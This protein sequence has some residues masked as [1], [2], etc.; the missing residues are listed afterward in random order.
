MLFFSQLLQSSLASLLLRKGGSVGLPC[1]VE[2]FGPWKRSKRE[3]EGN[4]WTNDD[5]KT[6]RMGGGSPL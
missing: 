4:V 6:R 2:G 1:W 5:C 3:E